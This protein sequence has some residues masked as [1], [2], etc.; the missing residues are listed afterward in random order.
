MR[1]L[2]S[3]HE[4]PIDDV[5][6]CICDKLINFCTD[7]KITPNMITLFRIILSIYITYL[8]YYTNN[9]RLII[10]LL[11]IFHFLDC[12][13]GHLARS[14]NQVSELGDYL[15]HFA[16]LSLYFIIFVYM[17]IK[18]YPNKNII[19]ISL[20]F[21]TYVLSCHIGLQQLQYKKTNPQ[22]TEESLD[23][24]NNFHNL[25]L[26]TIKYTKYFGHGTFWIII[27]F[28]IYYIKIS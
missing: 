9:I 7:Y 21:L 18:K 26:D 19:L 22:A 8:L 15:D 14:T 23:L 6:Y 24:C 27:I 2:K 4:N 13:D 28:F 10:V 16:D 17:L 1:K 11:I 25:S 5:L 20:I 3:E 12:M